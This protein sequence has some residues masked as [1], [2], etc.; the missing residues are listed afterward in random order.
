MDVQGG[1]GSQ[2]RKRMM[3][4]RGLGFTSCSLRGARR[5]SGI[6]VGGLEAEWWPLETRNGEFMGP[7]RRGVEM[8]GGPEAAWDSVRLSIASGG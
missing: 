1:G 3:Q 8:A 6:T 4:M 7:C 5:L 2:R